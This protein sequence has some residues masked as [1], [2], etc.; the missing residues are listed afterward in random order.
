M[1]IMANVTSPYSQGRQ[2]CLP[3]A[4]L[5][6]NYWGRTPNTGGNTEAARGDC[7]SLGPE[8]SWHVATNFG[9]QIGL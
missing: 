9:G 4:L 8:I 2:P 1:V 3:A 6:G 5:P 7:Q